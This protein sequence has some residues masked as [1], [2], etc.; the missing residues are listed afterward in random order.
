LGGGGATMVP[1]G[2]KNKFHLSKVHV[3]YFEIY[4]I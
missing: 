1:T 2:N 4:N 3:F